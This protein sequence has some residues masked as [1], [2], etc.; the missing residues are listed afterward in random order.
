MARKS[1]FVI[2]IALLSQIILGQSETYTIKKASFSSDKYDEFSPVYYKN[3][4]VFCSNRNLGFSN[5]STSQNKGLFKIYYIDT[6]GK[7]DWESTK[8]FSK[9][10]TTIL[11]D[12]PVS[13]NSLRDTIYFSRNQDVTS[14][15]SDISNPRNKLGIFSAVLVGSQWTKVRELR[16]NNEWYN[17]TTPCL[18]PDNKKLYF[19]SDRPGGYGGSD[20]YYSQWKNDRWEDPVN[21]GPVINTKGNE[22]YPFINPSGELF[23]S[24]DGHPGHGGK[25]IYFSY[26]SDTAWITPVC[27]DQPV[28]SRF[29]DFG[30]VT[31]AQMNE[32]YFSTN[33]D[34]SID[35]YYFKTNFPQILYNTIQKENQY[36]FMLN[37]SGA[38]E[39]DSTH[40]KYIWDFGDGE[41]AAGMVVSHCFKGAGKYIVKLDVIDKAT[42]NLFLSKLEYNLE[43][44]DYKQPYINAPETAVKGDTLRLDGVRSNLPG[45]KVLS[46]YWNFGDGYRSSGS[47]VRH[48]YNANGE[49]F[50]NM[51]LTLKSELTGFIHKTGVSRKILVF[52]NVQDKES[53]LAGKASSRKKL[54]D[55]RN[56]ENALIKT[57][58]SA[59]S[60]FMKDAIFNV[61][62]LSSRK[63]IGKDSW[64]FRNVPKKYTISE[65]FSPEDSTYRYIVD[66]QISLMSTYPAYNELYELGLK[67]VRIK[68]FVLK[69]PSE[70]ELHNL[71][72]INGAFADSYFD[73]SDKLTSNAYIMLD[74]I[75]KLMNKYP[76]VRLEVA[77]HSDNTGSPETSLALS[78]L[79]SRLLV[80]YMINRGISSKRLVATGFGASKPIAP[81]FLEKERKLNRRIDFIIL[82][83]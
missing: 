60:E 55:I 78:Q 2:M 63:K 35:I 15:L 48:A 24:S 43:L 54:P 47:N 42:G 38:L 53:Y 22:S 58:Y 31:D 52:N 27:L 36:C 29:D 67:N 11:N 57:K 34:K 50:V 10:I 70:K 40:L 26:F 56:S 75:I 71:I 59:E 12:G 8:L 66:Q 9:S 7:A 39:I 72:K 16:I 21:L 37:D 28:N 20:L 83:Q 80:A 46:Y 79:R 17:I 6:T 3:G 33:R 23:F 76:Y 64:S 73:S 19:A 82:T 45:Y 65:K 1:V 14:K 5:R 81:N 62:L 74:Q 41:K 4:I 44:L 61:E 68:T 32:G 77:V 25:D 30:I 13:F 18:S 49:F 51:E 69:D